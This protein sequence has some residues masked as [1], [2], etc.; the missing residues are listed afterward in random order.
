MKPG[1]LAPPVSV[2]STR[3]WLLGVH[4]EGFLGH[5][6]RNCHFQRTSKLSKTNFKI[7]H[8]EIRFEIALPEVQ[9]QEDIMNQIMESV[10]HGQIGFALAAISS[11]ERLQ[12]SF[13]DQFLSNVIG[14]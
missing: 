13:N 1:P 14:W 8:Y 3:Q 2:T 9:T 6:W 5:S 10:R 12:F 4:Y 11:A 7:E